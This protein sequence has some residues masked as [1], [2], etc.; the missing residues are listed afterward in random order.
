M[1]EM[2]EIEWSYF[3]PDAAAINNWEIR[4]VVGAWGSVVVKA[5]RY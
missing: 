3:S 1:S 2:F 5:L 4:V